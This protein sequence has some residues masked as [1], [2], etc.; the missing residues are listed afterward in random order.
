M[1]S[2]LNRGGMT[3]ADGAGGRLRSA[4][5]ILL[6]LFLPPTILTVS[7]AWGAE[8][9]IPDLKGRSGQEIRVPLVIDQTANLAGVK[10]ILHYNKELLT[11]REGVKTE[12]TQSLMHIIN[13]KTPGKLIVVMA[14]ARGIQGKEMTILTLTFA[15]KKGLTGNHATA[16]EAPEVQLMGDDLKEI[17]CRVKPGMIVILP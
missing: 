15:I 14:G 11:F 16:I 13:D 17:E 1:T 2:K 7:P 5:F 4:A 12:S 9:R 8:L 10:L 3:G 6:L